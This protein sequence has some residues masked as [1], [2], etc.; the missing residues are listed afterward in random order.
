VDEKGNDLRALAAKQEQQMAEQA[1][2]VDAASAIPE[3]KALH[4]QFVKLQ[5]ERVTAPFE[6]EVA[7]LNA[8]YVGGIDRKIAEEK[9]AGHLDGIIALEAEKKLL[10]D[11]QPIPADDAEGTTANLKALRGIYRTPMPRSRPPAWPT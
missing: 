2:V 11:Q 10:A 3:L 1:K 5:A 6:A 9:A 8:G 4:E 7:K